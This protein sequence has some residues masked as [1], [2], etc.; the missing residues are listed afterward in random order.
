MEEMYNEL[1]ALEDAYAVASELRRKCDIARRIIES[2]VGDV[3]LESRRQNLQS[4]IQRLEQ[5][6]D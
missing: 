1:I 6:L 5:K 4:A 2:T 3:L